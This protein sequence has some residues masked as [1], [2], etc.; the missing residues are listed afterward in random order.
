MKPQVY[1]KNALRTEITKYPFKK[2]GEVTPRIEHAI[3]G[4]VTE[5]GELMEA[6]KKVKFYGAKLDKV[7]LV[8]E[9]GD[10][11][12]YLAIFSNE[13]KVSFEEIWYKNIRKLKTRYPEKYTDKK[14][15]NR[16]LKNER[17]ELEK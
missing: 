7:N 16:N 6:I 12:W 11:M 3:D 1:I 9:L 10:I 13:L 2:T 17:K 8:E 15:Q 14:A 5:A 4:L